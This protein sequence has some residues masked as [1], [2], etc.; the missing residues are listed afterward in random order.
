M[1]NEEH[2]N[3]AEYEKMYRGK[4]NNKLLL[5]GIIIVVLIYVFFFTSRLT[6]SPRISSA[7]ETTIIG[8]QVEYGDQQRSYRVIDA[9]YSPE[10][11]MF[12]IV[13][14]FQSLAHDNVNDYYYAA[15]ILNGNSGKL[16]INEVYHED[17]F[18]VIRI[19]NVPKRYKELTFYFAPKLVPQEE[20]TDDMTG[21]VTLNRRNVTIATMDFN[22]DKT[23]YLEERVDTIVAD[24]EREYK[25]LKKECDEIENEIAA[26]DNEKKMLEENKEYMI[27]TEIKEKEDELEEADA[28]REKLSTDLAQKQA[29]LKQLADEIKSA[30]EKQTQI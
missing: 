6:L 5:I 4:N 30:K 23:K 12:E 8:E 28:E 16:D 24:T 27:D 13:F 19:G 21:S 9:I 14:D 22:K 1:N 3:S 2:I 18:T 25:K 10:Q 15:E 17:L 26:I 11:K 7:V 20:V 29:E